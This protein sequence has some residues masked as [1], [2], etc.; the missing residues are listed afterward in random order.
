MSVSLYFLLFRLL[1]VCKNKSVCV[2]IKLNNIEF[3]ESSMLTSKMEYMGDA[4]WWDERFRNRKNVLMLPEEKLKSDLK[5]F[6]ESKKILDLACG[7]G[8]NAI[9]LAKMGYEVYAVDFST[10]ALNR[11]KYFAISE[12][13]EIVTKLMDITSK[14]DVSTLEIKVDAVIV[15][16]YRMVREIYPFIKPVTSSSEF[17]VKYSCKVLF[18]SCKWHIL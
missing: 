6:A 11:L 8:R 13:L 12:R 3:G 7:D 4:T 1:A 15:N 17:V 9:F 5:Y 16:H 2:I 18:S 14:E 10:E